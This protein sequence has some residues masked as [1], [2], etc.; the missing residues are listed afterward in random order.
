L[1]IGDF[2]GDG[3]DDIFRP[4]NEWGGAEMFIS[5]GSGFECQGCGDDGYVWTGEGYNGLGWYVGDFNGDGEDDISRATS[6]RGGAEVLLSSGAN[7]GAPY[8]VHAQ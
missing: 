2:N 4:M 8:A 1:V 6:E 7:S 5:T 3:K